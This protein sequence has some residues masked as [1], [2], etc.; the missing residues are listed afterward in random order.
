MRHRFNSTWILSTLVISTLLLSGCSTNRATGKQSFTAF[1]SEEDEARI[2][3]EEHPKMLQA[4]GGT[5]DDAALEAY[6]RAIGRKLVAKSELPDAEFQFFVL[7]DDTVNAFAL[8][9]GYV[10]VSRGLIALCEDEAELAGV[11]GH[12][13]GH[14]TARHSAQRHSSAQATNIGLTAVGILGSIFG[15]P[16]GLNNVVSFGAQA[17]LQSYSRNQELEADRLGARYMSRAGY[18]PAALTDFF[19]KLDMQNGIEADKAGK[20]RDNYSVMSTHPRT[21]ERIEQ[22]RTLAR[23]NMP[24]GAKRERALFL[25]QVDGLIFGKDPKEGFMRGDSFVHPQIGFQFTFPPNFT[26]ENGKSAVTGSN[27]KIQIL[28]LIWKT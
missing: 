23:T 28:F 7:N 2:G 6:V 19:A 14:V 13:I 4:F 18:S 25:S 10:Y 16:T 11:I 27:G 17:A 5:Y 24:K 15:A 20:S 9:G 3:A 22:A 26:V 1:M 21:S 8:P 12:E